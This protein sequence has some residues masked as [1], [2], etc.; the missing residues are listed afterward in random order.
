VGS[1]TWHFEHGQ[2]SCEDVDCWAISGGSITRRSRCASA[3]PRAVI[4]SSCCTGRSTLKPPRPDTLPLCKWHIASYCQLLSSD[5]LEVVFTWPV[6]LQSY[7]STYKCCYNVASI[8]AS[9]E[10]FMCSA[11]YWLF[12]MPLKLYFIILH[13]KSSRCMQSDWF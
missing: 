12:S 8:V 3:R 11:G 13:K 1:F 5:T 10:T 7:I 4:M 2:C 9:A 6:K